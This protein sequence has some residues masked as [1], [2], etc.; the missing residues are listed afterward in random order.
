[1][2]EGS[3]EEALWVQDTALRIFT[4]AVG[5]GSHIRSTSWLTL[6]VALV[7][8]LVYG[9]RALTG[10][11]SSLYLIWGNGRGGNEAGEGVAGADRVI[12]PQG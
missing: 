1:M 11:R 12:S 5:V 8:I 6:G 4:G 9:G 10:I 2:E 3:E 7:C